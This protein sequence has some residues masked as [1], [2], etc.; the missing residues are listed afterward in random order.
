VTSAA[1]QQV[2]TLGAVVKS[3]NGFPVENPYVKIARDA[4]RQMRQWA[5]TLGLHRETKQRQ[6]HPT[7]APDDPAERLRLIVDEAKQEAG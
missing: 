5:D 6:R 2:N 4:S 3:P 1:E 7:D